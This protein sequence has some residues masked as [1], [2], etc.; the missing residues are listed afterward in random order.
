LIGRKL[1]YVITGGAKE[2]WAAAVVYLIARLNF[3]FDSKN[4]N[5]L[6]ADGISSFFGTKKTTMSAR[7]ADIEKACRIRMGQEGLCNPDIADMFI[8][9][10]LPNGMVVPKK[11]AR[12]A[13]WM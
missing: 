8:L 4:P 2:V 6:T 12:E 9:V 3:L 7:A 1:K 11:M 5:H 13:G 10:R